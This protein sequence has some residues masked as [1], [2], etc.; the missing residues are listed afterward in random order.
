MESQNQPASPGARASSASSAFL[1]AAARM[2]QRVP[3]PRV[4]RCNVF[5]TVGR[6]QAVG[7]P[8][9]IDDDGQ[10]PRDRG[11]TCLRSLG[12]GQRG[13]PD[14]LLSCHPC[15]S[16]MNG[17]EVLWVGC[18]GQV[19]LGAGLASPYVGTEALPGPSPSLS[20]PFC[21][22]RPASPPTPAPL[23]AWPYPGEAQGSHRPLLPRGLSVWA[24]VA[25]PTYVRVWRGPLCVC[26][27]GFRGAWPFVCAYVCLCVH[28]CACAVCWPVCGWEGAAACRPLADSPALCGPVG[29]SAWTLYGC[30]TPGLRVPHGG[31][32]WE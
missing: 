18:G 9:G 23:P 7:E 8:P 25:I 22:L 27:S 32:F 12:S 28:T 16:G 19:L 6:G 20:T 14:A 11:A 4:A 2:C 10:A 30:L 3:H 1:S 29:R 26:T 13:A 21:S 5:L 15:S 24:Q 31:S 17:P